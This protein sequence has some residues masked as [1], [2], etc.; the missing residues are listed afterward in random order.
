MTVFLYIATVLIWGST[1]LAIYFQLGSVDIVVSVFYRFAL[2]ALI[3]FPIL[4]WLRKIQLGSLKDQG[5]FVLQGLCLFSI[6]FLCFYQATHYI[7]SGLISVI[8]SLATLYNAVNNRLFFKVHI[9][10]YVVLASLLGV[11]GLLILFTAQ[12]QW[13]A[14][15]EQTLT[16]VILAALGT[17][18]F[19][20]GNMISARHSKQGLS[21]L[22]TNAWAMSYGAIFLCLLVVSQG[23]EL[24]WDDR[25]VYMWSLL[26]LSI[27]GTIVGF[28]TYLTLVARLGAN[29]AAY[30]TVVFPVIALSLS[31]LYE[32][33]VWT[34]SSLIG[35]GLIM[36]GNV[37]IM[38]QWMPRFLRVRKTSVI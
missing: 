21:P 11:S 24:A 29:R 32:G 1:W 20:L 10:A 15:L 25:P 31:S 6:N 16:G 14:S 34:T 23:Y 12:I 9:Q 36:L 13:D 38:K 37:V 8:F 7:Q 2:A 27:F 28:T 30:A 35:L 17:Y 18:C 33:Y 19:S 5:F 4:L 3:L 22:T 26:Y